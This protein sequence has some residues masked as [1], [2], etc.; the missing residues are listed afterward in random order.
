[1]PFMSVVPEL[2]EAAV[3]VDEGPH[4]PVEVRREEA[5]QTVG[6]GGAVQQ[7]PFGVLLRGTRRSW[8]L[9]CRCEVQDV[10]FMVKNKPRAVFVIPIHIINTETCKRTKYLQLLYR[11]LLKCWDVI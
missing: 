8:T 10:S 6:L 9:V 11:V 7:G 5:G 2:L 3:I 1:M 4:Q